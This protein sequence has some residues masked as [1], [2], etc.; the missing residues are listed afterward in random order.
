M[1]PEK[2]LL[3]LKQLASET[4][5]NFLY[6]HERLPQRMVSDEFL[7]KLGQNDIKTIDETKRQLKNLFNRGAH[8]K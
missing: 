8:C 3:K 2:G 4:G 6:V 7:I 5:W 1:T